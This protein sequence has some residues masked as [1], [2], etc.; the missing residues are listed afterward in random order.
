MAQKASGYAVNEKPI[1]EKVVAEG[2]FHWLSSVR[3][4]TSNLCMHEVSHVFLDQEAK[5]YIA[6]LI[7]ELS[8]IVIQQ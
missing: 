8:A 5:V 3:D 7:T 1:D 4:K 6:K 2:S